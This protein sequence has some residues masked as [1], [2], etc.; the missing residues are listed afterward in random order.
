MTELREHDFLFPDTFFIND[1]IMNPYE[2]DLVRAAWVTDFLADGNPAALGW[3]SSVAAAELF[4]NDSTRQEGLDLVAERADDYMTGTYVPQLLA[5]SAED[6]GGRGRDT[7]FLEKKG[8]DLRM[9]WQCMQ[10]SPL[11]EIIAHQHDGTEMSPAT[12]MEARSTAMDAHDL[13]NAILYLD[14][15]RL[16]APHGSDEAVLPRHSVFREAILRSETFTAVRVFDECFGTIRDQ[17]LDGLYATG[18]AEVRQAWDKWHAQD[19]FPADYAAA[20]NSRAAERLNRHD[21]ETHISGA[22]NRFTASSQNWS[23]VK[24]VLRAA[25]DSPADN[26]L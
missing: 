4:A 25:W 9:A 12:I 20:Y 14:L 1:H 22:W 23:A 24:R 2:S 10:D 7:N 3:F 17:A 16:Q 15:V 5:M 26:Q 11:S 21:H 18:L 8:N 13:G 19:F 6:S